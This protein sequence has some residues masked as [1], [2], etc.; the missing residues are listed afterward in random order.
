MKLNISFPATGCQKLIEVEDDC[1][2]SS[3]YQKCMAME[4]VADTLGEEWKWG[5]LTPDCVF[6][7][8]SKEHSCYR[9]RRTG[10]RKH[11]S[12]WGCIADVN[13]SVLNLVIV[14]ERGEG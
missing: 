3:F 5:V 2:L 11:K 14:K 6:L 1:K 10:E 8:L 9:P 12:V 4:V 7:L 13:L